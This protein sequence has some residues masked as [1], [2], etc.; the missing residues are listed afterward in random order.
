[1]AF[2]VTAAFSWGAVSLFGFGFMAGV[3]LIVA[4]VTYLSYTS[5][6][7][8]YAASEAISGLPPMLYAA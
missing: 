2:E 1:M 5:P 7:S 6:Y 3:F 4:F 8:C